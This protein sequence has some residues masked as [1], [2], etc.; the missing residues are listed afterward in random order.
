MAYLFFFLIG[1][2]PKR[3]R[4]G[5]LEQYQSLKRLKTFTFHVFSPMLVLPKPQ[6]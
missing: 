5:S 4:S 6:I 3:T 1:V 2:C